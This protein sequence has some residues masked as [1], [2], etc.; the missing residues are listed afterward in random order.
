MG[1]LVTALILTLLDGEWRWVASLGWIFL[2]ILLTQNDRFVF[3]ALFF[4]AAW[5]HPTGYL[6][7]LSFSLKHFQIIF[8]LDLI[9]R[10]VKGDLYHIFFQGVQRGK[11]LAPLLGI[12]FIGGVNFLRFGESWQALR[13]PANILLSMFILIYM[14]GL[15]ESFGRKKSIEIKKAVGFF[16]AAIVIQVFVALQNTIAGTFIFGTPL[17]HNNHIGILCACSF[18]YALGL[19]FEEK[20]G[21]SKN[22]YGLVGLIIF[23][24][25]IAS[26][27]RTSWLGLLFSLFCF[28]C[29]AYWYRQQSLVRKRHVI[30]LLVILSALVL[31]VTLVS[32]D[33]RSRAC[34]LVRLLNW[35]Y[36][37]YTFSD[38]QNFGFLGI[39]RLQQTYD[40]K[41]ILLKQP[42]LGIGF[43][44]QVVDFHGFYFCLLGATGFVGLFIFAGFVRSVMNRLLVAISNNYHDGLFFLRLASLCA[45]LT[46]LLCSFLESYFVQFS[47]WL[48]IFM[49]IALTQSASE[50][51]TKEGHV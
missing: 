15:Y 34:G 12:L 18:F 26:C 39:F 36:W 49:A 22:L 27:S 30:I 32:V 43:I 29:I 25:V 19:F 51:S 1:G 17:I 24:T 10:L 48:T 23:I 7:N 41:I 46:W 35:K 40:L 37:L 28:F 8:F 33:I 42:L 5:F 44:K 3:Y 50:L 47:A 14:L 11:C 13:T 21:R 20:P 6:T 31:I 16:L 38:F 2:A 9:V 45:F 4:F